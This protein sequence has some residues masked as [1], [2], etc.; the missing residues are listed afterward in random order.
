MCPLGHGRWRL[1][2]NSGEPAAGSAGEVVGEACGLTIDRFLSGVGAERPSSS[3]GGDAGAARPPRPKI[4]RSAGQSAARRGLGTC[5]GA[6]R[7][8]KRA[9]LAVD[10]SGGGLGVL[11]HWRL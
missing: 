4:R 7:G 11:L 6:R 8:L 2:P 10:A 9:R 3:A 1:R 5:G